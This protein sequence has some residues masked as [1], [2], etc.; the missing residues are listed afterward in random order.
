MIAASR[1][2]TSSP[3]WRNVGQRKE[4]KRLKVTLCRNRLPDPVIDWIDAAV[5]LI[6][7]KEQYPPLLGTGGNIGRLELSKGLLEHSPY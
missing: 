4:A 6:D 1:R 7:E 2:L 5:V 3:E